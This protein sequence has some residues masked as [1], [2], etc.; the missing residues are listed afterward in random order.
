MRCKATRTH[1]MRERGRDKGSR[2]VCCIERKKKEQPFRDAKKLEVRVLHTELNMILRSTPTHSL[3]LSRRPGRS[4]THVGTS[5]FVNE[6][7]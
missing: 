4:S 5:T 1:E 7:C 2:Q 6:A 3:Y